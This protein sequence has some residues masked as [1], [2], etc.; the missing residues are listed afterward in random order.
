MSLHS[1]PPTCMPVTVIISFG[2][3]TA[4]T[5]VAHAHQFVRIHAA[6]F[7]HWFFTSLSREPSYVFKGLGQDQAHH[8]KKAGIP[9]SGDMLSSVPD[10]LLPVTYIA[11]LSYCPVHPDSLSDVLREVPTATGKGDEIWRGTMER[12]L[13]LQMWS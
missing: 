4:V 1:L 13:A 8:F 2:L 5:S 12:S 3:F 11:R 6:C 7:V 9:C 10:T